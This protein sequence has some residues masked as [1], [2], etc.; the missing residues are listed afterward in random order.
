MPDFLEP[1]H[2]LITGTTG[3][4]KSYRALYQVVYS[5]IRNRPCCYIDP[6]G[7]L[8][9]ILLAF[10]ATTQQGRMLWERL[11]DRI[12]FLNPVTAGNWMMGFN[13]LAPLGGFP[14]ARPDLLALLAN[15]LVSHIR[16]QSGFEMAEA[17]RMQNVLAAAIGL[18]VEGGRGQYTLAELPLL[19][20]QPPKPPK[21]ARP[22][23][24]NRFVRSLLPNTSHAGTCSFWKDQWPTWT[25]TARREWVQSTEGRI[26]QYLFDERVLLTT[27]TVENATLDL[28]RVVREGYWL[29]VHLPYALLSD[30]VSTLLGNLLITRLLY[31]G[32]QRP[33]GGR[34]YRLILDEA[35]FFNTGPLD[36]LLETAR[37]YNLWLTLI[38]QSVDQM[39]RSREGR[40]DERL[41]ELV[42]N[43]CR[44][45]TVFQNDQDA[46]L[47]ARLMFPI[48]GQVPTGVKVSGD[49]EY[50]PVQAE[51]DEHMRRFMRLRHRESVFYD[52][53]GDDP[54]RIWYTP[55]VIMDPPD[56]AI[57]QAFEAAHLRRTGRPI[58]AMR[59]EIAHRQEWLRSAYFGEGRPVSHTRP[60]PPIG[61][62]L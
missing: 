28:R 27:C 31:A 5:L 40:M 60:K 11:Q 39:C 10:L 49:W 22:E 45:F 52:K 29:F 58:A 18:L 3:T 21:G 20:V 19:F 53:L 47:M 46:E 62:G 12:L 32:M 48:S 55:D 26:Y 35:R 24:Y 1:G 54:P 14:D 30:T 44:Y 36:V 56:D 57:V 41:K 43:L 2:E 37:A 50:L 9:R 61:E 16:R 38:V 42:M 34:P 13:V 15:M 4:G 23:D 51:Q 33:P 6:K 17:N 59:E 7:E 8:Y 25:P